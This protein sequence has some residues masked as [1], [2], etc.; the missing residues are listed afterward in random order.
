MIRRVKITDFEQ[1]RTMSASN[2]PPF[3]LNVFLSRIMF[4]HKMSYISTDSSESVYP[5]SSE[6]FVLFYV[7]FPW[8]E[9]GYDKYSNHFFLASVYR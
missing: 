1:V 3:S 6:L 7:K 2:Y 8:I 5:K 4:S 9:L